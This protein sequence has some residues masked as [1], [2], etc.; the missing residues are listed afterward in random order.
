MR[1]DE[2]KGV[3]KERVED[4]ASP[5]EGRWDGVSSVPEAIYWEAGD[6]LVI[7]IG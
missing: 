6:L 1:G 3:S 4:M 7:S 2:R 5:P